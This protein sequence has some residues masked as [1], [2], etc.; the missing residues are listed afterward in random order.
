MAEAMLL[1]AARL[2][3]WQYKFTVLYLLV[4]LI[5]V[6]ARRARVQPSRQTIRPASDA[7]WFLPVYV[8]GIESIHHGYWWLFE[9]PFGGIAKTVYGLLPRVELSVAVLMV[10]VGVCFLT[11]HLARRKGL[12]CRAAVGAVPLPVVVAVVAVQWI[13][14]IWILVMI[15]VSRA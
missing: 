4:Q 15:P 12:P 2:D 13:W 14:G 6:T 8:W 11:E 3:G 5:A 1:E 9:A 10:T 7:T